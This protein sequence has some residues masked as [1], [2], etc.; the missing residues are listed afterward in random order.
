[1]RVYLDTSVYDA[2]WLLEEREGKLIFPEFSKFVEAA[3][4]CM[5][6]I[7]VNVYLESELLRKYPNL[8]GTWEYFLKEC[9]SKALFV[10]IDDDIKSKARSLVVEGVTHHP[11]SIHL[12]T[13][14]KYADAFVTYDRELANAASR[15]IAVKRLSELI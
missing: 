11:D 6:T 4:G 9:K 14:I 5:H 1:M 3:A 12:T 15:L 13:A 8:A 7:I 10:E 2:A